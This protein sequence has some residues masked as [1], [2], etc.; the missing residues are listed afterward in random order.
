MNQSKRE[1][2]TLIELLVVIAIIGILIALLLPAVQSAR[3]AARGARCQNHLKQMGLAAHNHVE[4]HGFFPTGG[5]GWGWVGD[6]DRGFGERQPGGWLYGLLPFLEL[7]DLHDTGAGELPGRK[8]SLFV[9][10]ASTPVSVY[11]C[12]SRRPASVYPYVHGAG[13]CSGRW[14]ANMNRPQVIARTDYG[15]SAGTRVVEII[16]G[17]CSYSEAKVWRVRRPGENPREWG[18]ASG[19]AGEG[20][21]NGVIYQRSQVTQAQVNDGLSNT[22]LIGER[23]M[24]ADSYADYVTGHYQCDD[25]QGWDMGYDFDIN[26]WTEGKPL[27]DVPGYG[28]CDTRFGSI[29]AQ[30][31]NSVFCDGSVHTISYS[32]DQQVH[33]YL[34]NRKDGRSVSGKF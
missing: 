7:E 32:I 4:A 2:F 31:F 11:Y 28:T 3:E 26:V 30:G 9:K 19:P 8:M 23:Y 1:G 21:C 15:G 24:N 20:G 5:W 17:P 25:D 16:Y 34:S 22:Y 27:Q 12:P 18:W 10:V 14:W 6:P 29:H 33:R 13:P